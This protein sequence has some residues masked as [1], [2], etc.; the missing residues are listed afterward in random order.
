VISYP[1]EVSTRFLI[2]YC[3]FHDDQLIQDDHVRRFAGAASV[4]GLW[5]FVSG[6]LMAGVFGYAEMKAA[7][8]A[9][10]L[11]IPAGTG[12]FVTHTLI[13]LLTGAG[14]VALYAIFVRLISRTRAALA[15]AAFIWI[16]GAVFPFAVIVDWGLFSWSLAM[17]LWAWSAV[18]LLIAAFIGRFLYRPVVTGP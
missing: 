2:C 7:F 12:S 3:L 5:V 16:F 15:A 18:E 14:V 1:P 9:V 6:L 11:A 10:G 17:K 4:A 8:D 13:R